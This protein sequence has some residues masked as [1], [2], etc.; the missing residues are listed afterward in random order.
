MLC[1]GCFVNFRVKER[2]AGRWLGRS[3]KE[4]G[5]VREGADPCEE[6]PEALN[7]RGTFASQFVLCVH[8]QLLQAALARR[9]SSRSFP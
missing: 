8:F 6:R 5:G 4:D 9:C 7:T 1:S 3:L 2:S